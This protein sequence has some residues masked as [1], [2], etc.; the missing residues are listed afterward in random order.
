MQGRLWARL[1]STINRIN[2]KGVIMSLSKR[3][4]EKQEEYRSIAKEMLLAVGAIKTCSCGAITYESYDLDEEQIY[5]LITNYVKKKYP[6]NCD[7]KML[8]K[9]IGLV[10]KESHSCNDCPYCTN[11][12][13]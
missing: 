13:T 5:A 3:E 8:H 4:L 1:F 12:E 10:L 7:Y 9:Y 11:N 6:E 2:L